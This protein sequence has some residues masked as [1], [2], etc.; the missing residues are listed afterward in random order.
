MDSQKRRKT[1]SS[2]L[3]KDLA[4]GKA[5]WERRICVH[6]PNDND[7]QNHLVGQVSEHFKTWPIPAEMDQ[8]SF[9]ECESTYDGN[10]KTCWSLTL[11]LTTILS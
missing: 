9:S 4:C 7:H 10:P 11:A 6:F 8:M 2:K 3:R 1:A 5:I